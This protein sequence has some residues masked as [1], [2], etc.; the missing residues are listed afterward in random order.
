LINT[1]HSSPNHNPNKRGPVVVVLTTN[2]RGFTETGSNQ[3]YYNIY[4][5]VALV[6]MRLVWRRVRILPPQSLRVVR[7]DKKGTQSQMRW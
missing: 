4:N 5:F 3:T 1:T 7:G 2:P 6:R